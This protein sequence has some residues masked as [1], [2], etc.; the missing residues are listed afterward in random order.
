M[1]VTGVALIGWVGVFVWIYVSAGMLKGDEGSRLTITL[2]RAAP[3]Q[4]LY[5]AYLRSHLYIHAYICVR[6]TGVFLSVSKC[7]CVHHTVQCSDRIDESL[8]VCLRFWSEVCVYVCVYVCAFMFVN[9]NMHIH[10]H[11]CRCVHPYTHAHGC[12]FFG[13]WCQ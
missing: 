8:C 6:A 3:Q 11:I 13:C 10:I 2:Q 1:L 9:M 12:M 5:Y 4:V 7:K